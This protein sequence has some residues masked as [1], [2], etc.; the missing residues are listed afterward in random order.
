MGSTRD[1]ARILFNTIIGPE[2]VKLHKDTIAWRSTRMQAAFQRI[3]F[4][5]EFLPKR[6]QDV[7]KSELNSVDRYIRL[8]KIQKNNNC[9]VGAP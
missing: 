8:S 3:F 9:C 4:F 7:F 1:K 6:Y 5:S 2:G